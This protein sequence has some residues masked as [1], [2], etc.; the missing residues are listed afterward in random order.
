M[1]SKIVFKDSDGN[2]IEY[3]NLPTEVKDFIKENLNN[4]HDDNEVIID[5]STS[6]QSNSD[7]SISNEIILPEIYTE[8]NRESLSE[9]SIYKDHLT[10]HWGF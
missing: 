10:E 5:V 9:S 6:T 2:I 8:T 7:E 1:S 4:F 3:D